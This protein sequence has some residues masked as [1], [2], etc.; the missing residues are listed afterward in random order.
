MRLDRM[1]V[2]PWHF[3]TLIETAA[4]AACYS[5]THR[6]A[7]ARRLL[8]EV[9]GEYDREFATRVG[10]ADIL[11]VMAELGHTY[12]RQGEFAAAEAMFRRA[13]AQYDRREI[14]PLG[15][16]HYPRERVVS[17]LGH[18]LAGLGRFEAAE[19][20]ALEAYG[21]LHANVLELA[22]DG[23]QFVREAADAV[24]AVYQA[25]GKSTQATEWKTK[26]AQLPARRP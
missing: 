5:A 13:L 22:G 20:L 6:L 16:R 10:G 19:S 14:P 3:F 1:V 18:A 24:I 17:G 7:D 8:E 15:L 12:L 2:G 26:L 21:T 11:I 23:Y 25:W 9:V 4:V